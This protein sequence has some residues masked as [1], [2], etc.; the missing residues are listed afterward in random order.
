M[1]KVLGIYVKFTKTPHQ[2][3]SCQVTLA[4]NSE[5]F[6]RLIL[7]QILGKVTKFGGIGSRTKMLQ[8][9]NKLGVENTPPPHPVLIGLMLFRIVG[10]LTSQRAS[11]KSENF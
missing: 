3:W 9:K 6:F 11:N 10:L 4:S 1:S 7:Y 8:A 2:I 5:N